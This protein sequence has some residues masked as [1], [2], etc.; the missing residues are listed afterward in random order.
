MS[1]AIGDR[2][3]PVAPP[4]NLRVSVTDRD[5]DRV[6][7]LMTAGVFTIKPGESRTIE[8]S[9]GAQLSLTVLTGSLETRGGILATGERILLHEPHVIAA[10]GEVP[11]MVEI[12]FLED[13][14]DWDHEEAA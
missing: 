8:A 3:T 7:V 11:A 5:G 6:G 2:L 1:L 14:E 10:A 9:L 12:T 13:D 4:G